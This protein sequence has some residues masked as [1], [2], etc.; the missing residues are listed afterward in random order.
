[1]STEW[2]FYGD[3]L[4][5]CH[6]RGHANIKGLDY[7]QSVFIDND[8]MAKPDIVVDISKV[9][10]S[11]ILPHKFDTIFL[12]HCPIVIFGRVG[13]KHIGNYKLKGSFFKNIKRV[14]KPGGYLILDGLFMKVIPDMG[15]SAWMPDNELFIEH[16]KKFGFTFVGLTT[17]KTNM[18]IKYIVFSK[19]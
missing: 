7:S 11:T 12:V 13:I 14:L 17:I 8:P 18:K 9:D 15:D 1:M 16:M 19:D 5:L 3:T 6:G 2:N 4:I 10:L